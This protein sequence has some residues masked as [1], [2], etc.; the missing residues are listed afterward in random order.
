MSSHFVVRVVCVQGG[1]SI[2][3][4][5]T[6]VA[7]VGDVLEAGVGWVV[8]SM[9]VAVAMSPSGATQVCV[10]MASWR[11]CAAKMIPCGCRACPVEGM[12]R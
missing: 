11:Y 12:C 5:P 2:C 10:W 3:S 6:V 9:Y 7:D 1:G 8:W 4:F